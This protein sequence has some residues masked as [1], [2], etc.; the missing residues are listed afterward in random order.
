MN[1]QF[2]ETT[3][4]PFVKA[5]LGELQSYAKDETEHHHK[6]FEQTFVDFFEAT[7]TNKT[8]LTRITRE[9]IKKVTKKETKLFAHL[10]NDQT[11]SLL[12]ES[13]RKKYKSYNS[14]S[15]FQRAFFIDED[16]SNQQHVRENIYFFSASFHNDAQK[17][18]GVPVKTCSEEQTKR[19]QTLLKTVLGEGRYQQ[20]APQVFLAN[21]QVHI[22]KDLAYELESSYKLMV[23]SK[24]E[25]QI[26]GKEDIL[27]AFDRQT[28]SLDAII[29]LPKQQIQIVSAN[30]GFEVDTKV[31]IKAVENE[32][33]Q[34]KPS[35]KLTSLAGIEL[36][37]QIE[38]PDLEKEI[39]TEEESLVYA[40]G[41]L[42]GRDRGGIFN[43]RATIGDTETV[44][45]HVGPVKGYEVVKQKLPL[46]PR[47]AR[48]RARQAGFAKRKFAPMD[49]GKINNTQDYASQQRAKA[50][51]SLEAE[52]QQVADQK[53]APGPQKNQ[54][55][56]GN[57]QRHREK[58]TQTAASTPGKNSN[59]AW[60]IMAAS[61]GITAAPVSFTS[62]VYMMSDNKSTE[63]AKTIAWA[64]D[65]ANDLLANIISIFV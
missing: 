38:V 48:F 14:A 29:K 3:L 54:P 22:S 18:E 51:F 42:S 16:H 49:Y 53:G 26:K 44:V 55:D 65:G 7:E 39:P 58:E 30:G 52:K 20:I 59:P 10:E 41:E 12:V 19:L 57:A 40:P 13:I 1:K 17:L 33:D 50:R 32:E 27:V 25:G 36:K 11:T 43:L 63:T 2:L 64:V 15:D 34:V 62:F 46:M 35:V 24:F 60:K 21:N 8:R 47:P 23:E 45:S 4:I 28:L 37:A 5:F 61:A 31:E 6:S 56:Q 9:A